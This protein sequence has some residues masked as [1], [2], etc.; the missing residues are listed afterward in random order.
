MKR[1]LQKVDENLC[2]CQLCFEFLTLSR[3]VCSKILEP[4]LY[5][6]ELGCVN[7]ALSC[8]NERILSLLVWMFLEGYNNCNCVQSCVLFNRVVFV[9]AENKTTI[10]F[11]FLYCGV[12]P[13]ELELPD[14][15]DSNTNYFNI[16]SVSCKNSFDSSWQ[17]CPILLID[18]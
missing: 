5:K 1:N 13:R 6:I 2:S 15:V 4:N 8:F 9:L 11:S 7:Y 17:H 14:L 10:S 16:W 12:V 18:W 3:C